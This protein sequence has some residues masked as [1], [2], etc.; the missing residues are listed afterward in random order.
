MT[1]FSLVLAPPP[2]DRLASANALVD[3]ASWIYRRIV[4]IAIPVP[5]ALAL[6]VGIAL[7]EGR[8]LGP[9]FLVSLYTILGGY[10]GLIVASRLFMW[11]LKVQFSASTLK[12]QPCP[13]TLSEAGVTFEIR[14]LPWS[15]TL[16]TTRWKN[17]TLLHF[18]AIDALLIP[19]RD[20]PTGVTPALLSDQILAWRK[21]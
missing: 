13:V 3:R 8:P 20:L 4:I 15:A 7:I 18:S 11:R 9:A 2:A 19:D 21:D 14:H 10:F 16:G 5:L 1:K 17:N 6:G 12:R